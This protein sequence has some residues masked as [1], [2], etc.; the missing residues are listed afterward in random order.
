MPGKHRAQKGGAAPVHTFSGQ[1]LK[2]RRKAAGVSGER[3]A[4]DTGRSL[5]SIS[6]YEAGRSVPS[7]EQ[8][9]R[10]ADALGCEPGD[11]YEVVEK[12]AA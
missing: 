3:L 8:V 5:Y 9:A 12:V 6:A 10:M 1:R 7:A 11:F 4:V 2:E